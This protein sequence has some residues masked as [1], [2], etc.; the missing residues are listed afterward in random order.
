MKN[1]KNKNYKKIKMKKI[2][3]TGLVCP[4]TYPCH[5]LTVTV[6]PRYLHITQ[7]V[8]GNCRF[9]NRLNHFVSF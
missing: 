5:L 7:A 9:G 3:M 4:T 8:S 1:E 6:S 2:K